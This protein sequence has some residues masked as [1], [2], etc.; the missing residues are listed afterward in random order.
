MNKHNPPLLPEQAKLSVSL[1]NMR[2]IAHP[3]RMQILSVIAKSGE[4]NVG[5]IYKTLD[6]EQ[7]LASQHLR[8]LRNANLVSTRRD[9]KFIFYSLNY[10]N[11]HLAVEKAAEL[12]EKD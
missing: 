5:E 3:L 6:I 2:A 7:A 10:D 11:I 9:Q 4:L 1:A 8:I 12:S